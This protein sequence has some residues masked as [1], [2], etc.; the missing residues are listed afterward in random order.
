MEVPAEADDVDAGWTD[1]WAFHTAFE[2]DNPC[3]ADIFVYDGSMELIELDR[4]SREVG[5]T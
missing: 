5:P 3:A 2:I 1:L 4:I